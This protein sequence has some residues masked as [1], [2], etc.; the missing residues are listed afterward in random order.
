MGEWFDHLFNQHKLVRR[1]LVIWA[2]LLITW[3]VVQVFSD[4]T[5]ITA[6][7]ATALGMITAILSVVI[8]HYQWSRGQDDANVDN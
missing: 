1:L 8:G 7:V 5:L 2:V 4:L 3:V 6:A